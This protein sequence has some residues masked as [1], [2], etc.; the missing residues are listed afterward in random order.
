VNLC[1]V[2]VARRALDATFVDAPFVKH[3][4]RGRAQLARIEFVASPVERGKDAPA[5]APEFERMS[6]AFNFRQ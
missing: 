6:L 2:A 5:L 1:P 3:E 4:M